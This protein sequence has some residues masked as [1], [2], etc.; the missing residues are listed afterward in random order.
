MLHDE[1]NRKTLQLNLSKLCV[2]LF[3]TVTGPAARSSL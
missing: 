1:Q 3:G 2:A